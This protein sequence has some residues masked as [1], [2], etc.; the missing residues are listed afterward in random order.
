MD[1]LTGT[2]HVLEEMLKAAEENDLDG[3]L[4]LNQLFSETTIDIFL[5]CS[6]PL[7]REYDNFRQSCVGAVLWANRN[8]DFIADAQERF[9]RIQSHYKA[10]VYLDNLLIS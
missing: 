9:S 10:K 3:V 5:R 7:T 6:C 1:C 4:L 8:E 2:Y